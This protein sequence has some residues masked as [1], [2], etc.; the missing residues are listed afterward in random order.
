M[1]YKH[2][3]ARPG[4]ATLC[5]MYRRQ[6]VRKVKILFFHFDRPDVERFLGTM[7]TGVGTSASESACSLFSCSIQSRRSL[8]PCDSPSTDCSGLP[9]E[10]CGLVSCL[11]S[12]IFFDRQ[13]TVLKTRSSK[14]YSRKTETR[15]QPAMNSTPAT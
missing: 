8:D 12:K 6:P 9:R 7:T 5:F 15:F 13:D 4:R 3:S 10:F 11:V 14:K 2:A 1:K